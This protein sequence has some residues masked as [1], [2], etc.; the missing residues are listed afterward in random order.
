VSAPFRS[1][2]LAVGVELFTALRIRKCRLLSSVHEGSLGK[3]I[4]I[5]VRL[6]LMEKGLVIDR[7]ATIMDH[8]ELQLVEG[9]SDQQRRPNHRH[10]APGR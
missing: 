9:G 5:G 7:S 10:I 2:H 1:P 6:R 3:K 4:S 8:G